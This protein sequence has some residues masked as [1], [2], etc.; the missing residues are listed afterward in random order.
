[1]LSLEQ[2]NEIETK[3]ILDKLIHLNVLLFLAVSSK[4]SV[5]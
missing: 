1:M 2:G 4:P 5:P 3:W